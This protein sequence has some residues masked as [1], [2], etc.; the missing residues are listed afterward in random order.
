MLDLKPEHKIVTEYYKSLR[1]LSESV[2][3]ETSIRGAFERLLEDCS[4]KL[5]LHTHD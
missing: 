3:K 1:K 5:G 4:K 2:T